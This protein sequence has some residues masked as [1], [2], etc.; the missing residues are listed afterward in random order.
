MKI[1]KNAGI[2]GDAGDITGDCHADGE[3]KKLNSREMRGMVEGWLRA[4]LAAL[5]PARWLRESL[6]VSA[7][8]TAGRRRLR[9][10]TEMGECEYALFPGRPLWVCGLGKAAAAMAEGLQ[11]A[12]DGIPLQGILALP[13]SDQLPQVPGFQVFAGGHPEPNAASLEAGQAMLT[14]AA[15]LP[16]RTLAIFLISGGGST[17][18]EALWRSPGQPPWTLLQAQAWAR[19]LVL[20]GAPIGAI[21]IL[22]K[23]L[24][25][26]KGGRLAAAAAHDGIEQIT[27]LLSD[28]PPGDLSSVASGPT[29]PDPST[30][31]DA[32][33][34]AKEYKIEP[35][36]PAR[37]LIQ[38][39]SLAETHKPGD[40]VFARSRWRLLADNQTVCQLLAEQARR[41]GYEPVLDVTADEWDYRQAAAWLCSRIAEMRRKNPRA[42]LI[43]GGEVRVKVD[44]SGGRGGRNQAF[45][46]ECA[47]LLAGQPI[48]AASLGTD[49]VDGNSHL[50]GAMVDGETWDRARRQGLDP[51]AALAGFNAT[52]LFE[53]LGEGIVT[54]PTGNNLRDVRILI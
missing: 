51:E 43:A 2:L 12:L 22:R 24:S 30:V 8:D 28:V 18:A 53:S 19:S 5:A 9:L 6:E 26:L 48:C 25:A 38:S 21:N 49:G 50:A 11:S 42:C 39:H 41:A 29:L 54:G 13:A 14:A 46:L 34:A 47:R 10:A 35:P 23:H 31:E 40:S 16:A 32:Y 20:S 44:R 17:L 1:I 3:E 4:T 37:E 7:P 33:R 45:A 15:G 27:L 36:S 52:P